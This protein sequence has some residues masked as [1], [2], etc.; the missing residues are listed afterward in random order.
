MFPS[1]ALY[2]YIYILR[3]KG[4]MSKPLACLV[5]GYIGI[6]LTITTRQTTLSGS[7]RAQP[8]LAKISDP[9]FGAAGG[10][11]G[12]GPGLKVH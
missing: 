8:K 6:I 4:N 10:E 2:I 3:S 11:N 5:C 12:L 9:R 7:D 1:P